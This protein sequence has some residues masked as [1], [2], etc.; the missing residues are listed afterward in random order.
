MGQAEVSASAA[1]L[2]SQAASPRL[3]R[4]RRTQDGAILQRTR[5]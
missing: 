4:L 5:S 2:T 3:H 1:P